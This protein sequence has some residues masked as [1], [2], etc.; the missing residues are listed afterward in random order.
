MK[1]AFLNSFYAPDEIGGAERSVRFLAEELVRNGHDATVIASAQEAASNDLNG[2]RVQK[3]T[4]K[5]SYHPLDDEK[6]GK[7]GRLV[8]HMRDS[9]NPA[10]AEDIVDAL[11]TIR[12]DVFHTN[13]LSGFSVSAWSAAQKLGI[14]IVH[15][16]R[17]YYLLCPNT[18]MF[19]N[20]K[21]CGT[22]CFECR[23]L[24][25]PRAL[26]TPKVN[27]VVGNSRFI[28][29]RHV[30]TG[31]FPNATKRVV[32]NAY[33]PARLDDDRS[34]QFLTIGFIGRITE[35][36]GVEV[37]LDAFRLA[38]S[39]R[40]G[41][42]LLIAGD[43]D[44]LYLDTL[45]EQ[46]GGLNVEFCG[47][48][49]PA[50]FY[51]RIDW[52]VVPSL[53]HEPLARVIFEAFAHGVPVVASSTGGSPELVIPGKTG[54]LYSAPAWE[55]LGARLAELPWRDDAYDAMRQRVFYAAR[56]FVPQ[57]VYA[58]YMTI[59]SNLLE[60]SGGRDGLAVEAS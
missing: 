1:V 31:L 22:Q 56:L 11:K 19:K 32:Y 46:A 55:E 47:K 8:W 52:C 12:P 57:S 58:G 25:M 42:R 48:V 51:S 43:G 40:Q 10:A 41:M 35:T 38:S 23:C 45:R 26:A 50:D 7:F 28:L 9:L 30:D 4:I 49:E 6:P 34:N 15:T 60:N 44:S 2:V 29:D 33:S 36:K 37:L 16:L 20:G 18:A 54:W 17:D 14:P 24:G 5:N 53:W 21:Q 13:N 3:L 39:T 27:V 59:Y